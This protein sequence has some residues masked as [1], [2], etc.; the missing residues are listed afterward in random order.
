MHDPFSSYSVVNASSSR[1][2]VDDGADV[3]DDEL[4]EE[5]IEELSEPLVEELPGEMVDV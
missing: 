4:D 3:V 2:I 5:V 1:E